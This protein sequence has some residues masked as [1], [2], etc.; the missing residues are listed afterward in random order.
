MLV[1]LPL[2]LQRMMEEVDYLSERI[3]ILVFTPNTICNYHSF[4]F[5]VI[6]II[7]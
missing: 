7:R 2:N 1:Y 3:T 6:K 4:F 5:N